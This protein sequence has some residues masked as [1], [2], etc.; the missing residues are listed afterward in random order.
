MR[1]TSSC[2]QCPRSTECSRRRR[3]T[4]RFAAGIG[5]QSLK[6]GDAHRPYEMGGRPDQRARPAYSLRSL[7]WVRDVQPRRLSLMCIPLFMWAPAIRSVSMGVPS[8]ITWG[9]SAWHSLSTRMQI[10]DLL[11]ENVGAFAEV[12]AAGGPGDP[13]GAGQAVHT[14]AHVAQ[15]PW[16][17]VRSRCPSSLKAALASGPHRNSDR[18]VSPG[19]RSVCMRAVARW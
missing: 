19:Y 15:A 3:R 8:K 1:R 6:S 11:C 12:T 13:G 18:T 4:R 2:R 10:W 14:S 16:R 17:R 5:E 9:R 7:L